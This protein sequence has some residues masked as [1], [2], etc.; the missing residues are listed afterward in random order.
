VHSF[1][2]IGQTAAK[3]LR[4][5][6]FPRW[7]RQRGKRVRHSNAVCWSGDSDSLLFGVGQD[8]RLEVRRLSKLLAARVE[9]TDVRPVPGV[10]ADVS[11]Q[12]EVQRETL[13]TTLECTLHTQP[14]QR[15]ANIAAHSP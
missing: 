5:F 8:V 10:N 3:I 7:R 14:H 4:F 13:S 9:R 1:V 15:L 2:E 11:S 12:V 6:Y